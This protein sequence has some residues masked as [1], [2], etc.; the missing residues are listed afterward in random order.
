MAEVHFVRGELEQARDLARE[1]LA[2]APEV[3][4]LKRQLERFEYA[5]HSEGRP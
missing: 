5:I 1:A 4:Y 3:P 2:L